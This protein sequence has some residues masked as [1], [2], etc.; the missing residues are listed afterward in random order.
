M[1][2]KKVLD[3]KG[4]SANDNYRQTAMV[5]QRF[6]ADEVPFID[7]PHGFEKMVSPAE[8]SQQILTH[9]P[10]SVGGDCDD[11]AVLL[12]AMLRSV[13]IPASV[14]FLDTDND[15]EIDH[16]MTVVILDG[17]SVYAETTIKG[18]PFGWRPD[19]SKEESLLAQAE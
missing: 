17:Q 10:G 12:A 16:A 19:A 1:L 5:L 15:G 11:K 13:G 3:S 8:L 6:M 2:T 14:A 9:A 7:D 18:A 4:I